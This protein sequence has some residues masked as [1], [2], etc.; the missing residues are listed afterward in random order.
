MSRK[1]DFPSENRQ[2]KAKRNGSEGIGC[3]ATLSHRGVP[4][5]PCSSG[6]RI[7]Q[8]SSGVNYQPLVQFA[9]RT[10]KAQG[11]E[12]SL[13]EVTIKQAGKIAKKNTRTTNDLVRAAAVC[14]GKQIVAVD[15]VVQVG[16][17]G[18]RRTVAVQAVVRRPSRKSESPK[19]Q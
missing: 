18:I 14:L 17:H 1:L 4:S 6:T 7:H 13:D 2:R 5:G 15:S 16:Q 9:P 10:R 11:K 3:D 8:T 12:A 19:A